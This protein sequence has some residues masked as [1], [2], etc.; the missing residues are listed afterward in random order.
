MTILA[1]CHGRETSE[2][3]FSPAK[4]EER[5]RER[6]E[7]YRR[8]DYAASACRFRGRHEFS[9]WKKTWEDEPKAS[10][11]ST[12]VQPFFHLLGRSFF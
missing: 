8:I 4:T 6:T 7:Q 9:G 1:A 12:C 10:A 2:P 11:P 3:S 5:R